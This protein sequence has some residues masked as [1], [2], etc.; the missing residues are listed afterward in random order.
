MLS[1]CRLGMSRSV[2]PSSMPLRVSKACICLTAVLHICSGFICGIPTHADAPKPVVGV[3][4]PLSGYLASIGAAIR[5]GTELARLQNPE[6]MSSIETR[7]E[8]DQHDPKLALT[9][10]RHLKSGGQPSAIMAFGYFFP[11]VVGKDV[12]REQLPLINL[13][14]LA[15]PAIGNPYIV[16][17]MNHTKQYAQALAEFIAVGKQLDYPVVTTQY[18]FF[19]QLIGEAGEHLREI[20]PQA[21]LSVLAE[22]LPAEREFRSIISKLKGLNAER[23]GVFLLP[24]QLATFM[25]QARENG[26]TAEIFGSDICETA[27]EIA[28]VRR[29]VYGC[30]YPDNQ[31]TSQFRTDYRSRFNNE[32]QITFAGA[33]YDMALVLAEHFKAHPESKHGD[34]VTALST[35]QGRSGV[36]GTFSYRDD[37]AFGRF[38]EYP[39]VVKRIG[40]SGE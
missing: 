18:D 14:F 40:S 34:I 26:I 16:R 28:G 36:L 30:A 20:K 8:D 15:K 1:K 29:Y 12:A 39:V 7:F 32:S 19:L 3:I 38:F 22:V 33:A 31:V 4:A 9:V 37:P 35:I 6:V 23:L 27:A 21:K 11:T 10:Y 17:S 25:R 24:D 2:S 13:S 5:N